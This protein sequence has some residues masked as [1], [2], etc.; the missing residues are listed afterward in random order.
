MK[1][2]LSGPRLPISVCVISG[3]EAHRIGRT[4]ASIADWTSEIC[5]VIN[6]EVQDGTDDIARKYGATIFR[7]SWKGY[8]AQMNSAAEKA[9]QPWILALDADEV[10]TPDSRQ[11]IVTLFQDQQAD[12]DTAY[13]FPRCTCFA[14][15]W[16]RHGENYPDRQ[17][18]LW[19]KGQAKW[20]GVDPHYKLEV[21]G[22]V[23]KLRKD[24]LHYSNQTI[25]QQLSKLASYSDLFVKHCLETNRKVG[26][27]DL[28]VRPF[29]RF[30]RS[31]FLLRGF[32]DG[33]AGYYLAWHAAFS[34]ATRYMKVREAR[35]ERQG[36]D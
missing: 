36:E 31:Y 4:L 28:I 10:V 13:S 34:T 27:L 9:T 22:P 18:R 8:I 12:L 15:R 16:L 23:K 24:M 14:G 26:P 6:A 3:A 30:F 2:D 19:K 21:T 5:V 1:T 29:W 20:G 25:N 11:E 17:V 33:W 7:E 32:L 35:R